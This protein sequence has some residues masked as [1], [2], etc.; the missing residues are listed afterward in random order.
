MLVRA[1]YPLTVPILFNEGRPDGDL[2][3]AVTAPD[4][5]VLD[6]GAV[7]PA[8]DA[9]SINLQIPG[10]VHSLDEGEV[11]GYRDLTWSFELGGVL[12]VF[13]LRYTLEGR[14]PFGVSPD[15]VRAKLGVDKV[16]LPDSD[17]S[18]AKAY[19]SFR[20]VVGA[21]RLLTVSPLDIEVADAIEAQ[22]ALYLIPSMTV[23]V[24]AKQSSGTDQFQRQKIDW[25]ALATYLG[26]TVTAGYIAV[27]PNYDE[28]AGYGGLFIVA[29]AGVDRLTGATV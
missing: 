8:A 3:Y 6:S 7:T 5:S 4:G 14:L 1:G 12:K 28:T 17:I 2:T 21:E 20:K 16:D 27:D 13:D 26:S 25:E 23:R 18:L 22:A 9:V 24:A 29:T 11:L 10:D 15:G 19:L